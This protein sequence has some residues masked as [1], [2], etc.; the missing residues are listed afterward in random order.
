MS[1]SKPTLPDVIAAILVGLALCA[2]LL[3][4]LDALFY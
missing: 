1:D 2:L 3:H 4:S